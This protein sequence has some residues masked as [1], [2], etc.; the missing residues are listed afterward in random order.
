[1]LLLTRT[2]VH[3]PLAAQDLFPGTRSSKSHKKKRELSELA[4]TVWPFNE[5]LVQKSKQY[6]QKNR[7]SRTYK[8]LVHG[9]AAGGVSFQQHADQISSLGVRNCQLEIWDLQLS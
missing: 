6:Q 3:I 1:M 5:K 9:G 8:D 2:S 4:L 7:A